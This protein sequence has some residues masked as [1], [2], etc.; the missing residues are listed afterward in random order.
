[1]KLVVRRLRFSSSTRSMPWYRTEVAGNQGGE[2]RIVAT[3]L[4]EMDKLGADESIL[5]IAT[6]QLSDA[7]DLSMRRAGRFDIELA[8]RLPDKAGR[9]DILSLHTRRTPIAGNVDLSMIAARTP[10]VYRCRCD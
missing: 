6:T 10:G 4:A 1:M 8:L 7:L 3:L 9:R 2:R 5:I